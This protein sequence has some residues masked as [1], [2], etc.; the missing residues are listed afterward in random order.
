MRSP[1]KMSII[2]IELTNACM[3]KCSNCTRLC[4]HHKKPFFMDFETFKKACKSLKGFQ[5]MAGM[6]GG[7]PTLHPKFD[8]YV[9]YLVDNFGVKKSL[10]RG[11]HPISEFSDYMNKE[12]LSTN[13]LGYSLCSS[14]GK[15]YYKHFELIQETFDY[16]L[17][18]DH[19]HD[20]LHQGI[21]VSRKDV[22]IPDEKWYS[23][24][25]SCWLQN[26]WSASITPKG[27]FFCEVAGT[28]DL[29][30]DGPGG[31]DIEPGWW[32]R[33]PDQFGDQ[34]KWCE[35]CGIAFNGPKTQAKDE[36]DDISPSVFEKLKSIDSPRLKLGKYKI[37]KDIIS[38][39]QI[40]SYTPGKPF[41]L[42]D[43]DKNERMKTGAQELYPNNL[44]CISLQDNALDIKKIKK[45]KLSFDDL[46][47]IKESI[48][49]KL[50]A[51]I[52]I[53]DINYLENIHITLGEAIE[54]SISIINIK[55]WVVLTDSNTVLSESWHERVSNTIFNPGCLYLYNSFKT[56]KNIPLASTAFNLSSE[57]FTFCMF[58]VNAFTLRDIRWSQIESID[59]LMNFW[60]VDKIIPFDD[61]F[62]KIISTKIIS[63]KNEEYKETMKSSLM[64]EHILSFWEVLSK[65]YNQIALYGAGN[66]TVWL[67]NLLKINNLNLPIVI[68]D[69]N[70]DEK[71]LE[72]IKVMKPEEI[73]NTDVLIISSDLFSSEMESKA[74]KLWGNETKIFN[75]YKYFKNPTF[76]K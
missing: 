3:N 60:T 13:K 21:L 19:K 76:K 36:L 70:F 16:Q 12:L 28:L 22:G 51:E 66:H 42:P 45:L 23:I 62:D 1:S 71:E 43:G 64:K 4:S 6:M 73:L 50:K 52:D 29:L 35:L 30:F 75:P 39:P 56:K 58:N 48:S 9:R 74:N 47:I 67:L 15:H 59:D 31:W 2:Q 32:E 25:D 5:G 49:N 37:Y 40:A 14:I 17:L 41:Y 7:E 69:D 54:K 33:T 46:I 10:D 24:R 68:Y 44:K 61:T 20:G 65:S 34:L 55:D 11:R 63:N 8:K 18:N 38:S 27:A 53:S 26:N 72:G 57:S